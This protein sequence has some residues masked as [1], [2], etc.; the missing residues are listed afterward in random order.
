MDTRAGTEPFVTRLERAV[1]HFRLQAAHNLLD[2]AFAAHPPETLVKDVGKPLLQRL[3]DPAAHRFATSL[4]EL[5]LLAH[6]QGWERVN[7]PL[8]VLA[9]APTEEDTLA[10]I[11]LGI[12]L[13]E[14][15]CRIAYLGAATPVEAVEE[16]ARSQQAAVTVLSAERAQL[17]RDEAHRLKRLE[18]PLIA[19]GAAREGLA[20]Q[21]G[22]TALDVDAPTTAPRIAGMARR[23]ESSRRSDEPSPT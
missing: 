8:A 18:C 23:W 1:R 10:L 13:A 14:R 12:A 21:A 22:A 15:H 5:R 19:I 9:C 6:A 4:L 7:G 16:T 11:A 17:A 2:E 20:K 3:E